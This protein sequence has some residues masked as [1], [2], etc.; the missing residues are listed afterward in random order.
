MCLSYD[1]DSLDYTDPGPAAIR[2][3]LA[4]ARNGSLVSLHFGHRDTVAAMPQILSSLASG[5]LTPV[6]ADNLLAS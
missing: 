4:A 3:N 1:I 2:Q 5:G 6:T